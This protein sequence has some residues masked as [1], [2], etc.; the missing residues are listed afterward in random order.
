MAFI[1]FGDDP[2][3]YTDKDTGIKYLL[4]QPTDEVDIALIEY[5]KAYPTIREERNKLFEENPIELRKWVS[6]HLN[7][8]L[9]GWKAPEGVMIPE[10]TAG[11]SAEKLPYPLRLDILGFWK[12]GNFISGDDLKK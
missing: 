10:F 8:I 5:E 4:K 3:A 12:S 2:I 1:P 7:I 11:S 6:G 9:C